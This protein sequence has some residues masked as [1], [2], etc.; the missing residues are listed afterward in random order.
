M[1][2]F[3]YLL[4]GS[5]AGLIAG[6]F[7]VGGGVVVVPALVITFS[8]LGFPA[9]VLMQL[10]VGTSLATIVVTSISAISAHYRLG[11][12]NGRIFIT[13]APGMV[14]GVWLGANTLGRLNGE[15]LQLGFGLFVILIALQ[16]AFNIIPVASRS[17]PSRPFLTVVGA[18]IG[19]VSALFGIGGGSMTVPFLNRYAIAM[20]Q[21]VGTSSACGL[22]IALVGA[23]SSIYVGWGLDLPEFSSGFV[24]WPAFFGI[25]LTSTVFAKL[26]ASLA[27][28][29]SAKKLKRIFAVFL[30]LIGIQFIV[31]NS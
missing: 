20:Q 26:G 9:E 29:F 23:L 6:M 8:L 30:F 22:P 19:Y 12:V 14:L 2:V 5:I 15:L 10:A 7:G 11:N 28:R 31:R 4:V 3:I 24:Y 18:G 1:T 27:N 13:L 16:M 17:L 25:V 21:A